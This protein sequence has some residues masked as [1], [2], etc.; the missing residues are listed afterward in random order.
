MRREGGRGRRGAKNYR[1]DWKVGGGSG[2]RRRRAEKRDRTRVGRDGAKDAR[3]I[4]TR[5]DRALTEDVD[6]PS[7]SAPT[8]ARRPP[9]RSSSSRN[10]VHNACAVVWGSVSRRE[11]LRTGRDRSIHRVPAEVLARRR[12][13]RGDA[14]GGTRPT[15]RGGDHAANLSR[16]TRPRAARSR[17]STVALWLMRPG[18]GRRRQ[19]RAV[20]YSIRSS[21]KGWLAGRE[22]RVKY[23]IQARLSPDLPG[24]GRRDEL[25][26]G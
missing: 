9:S 13:R 11:T 26:R 25:D 8:S 7:P 12:R 2:A 16:L 10:G 1:L 23:E 22:T 19:T 6:V 20:R 4:A 5:V 17:A 3:S 14:R 15:A 18:S 24:V 21:V